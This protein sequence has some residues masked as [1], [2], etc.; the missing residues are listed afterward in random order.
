[1]HFEGSG[2]VSLAKQLSNQQQLVLRRGFRD[3]SCMFTRL[4]RSY[5]NRGNLVW[6][7]KWWMKLHKSSCCSTWVPRKISQIRVRKFF[8]RRMIIMQIKEFRS[9]SMYNPPTGFSDA[10]SSPVFPR[11]LRCTKGKK[12]RGEGTGALRHTETV[13]RRGRYRWYSTVSVCI[14][15]SRKPKHRP[16]FF[17]PWLVK[18]KMGMQRHQKTAPKGPWST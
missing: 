8:S 13:D 17:G 16:V 18:I 7:G 3:A 5:S 6:F 15:S 4:W 1:M 14:H 2:P 9:T 12:K 10:V 11:I